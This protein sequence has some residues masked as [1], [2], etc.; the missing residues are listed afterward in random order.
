MIPKLLTIEDITD[1]LGVGRGTA[2]KIAKA[3]KHTKTTVINFFAKL[4]IFFP[5]YLFSKS[6][7]TLTPRFL[8]LKSLPAKA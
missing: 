5:D 3:I 8:I 7:H 6:C 4:F 2:Y 1:M